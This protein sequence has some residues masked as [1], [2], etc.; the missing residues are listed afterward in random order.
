MRE[1]ARSPSRRLTFEDAVAIQ[2]RLIRR[3]FQN[4]IAA[5]YDVNSGRIAEIKSGVTF[6]GSYEA[7]LG[8]NDPAP[9]QQKL[10]G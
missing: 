6:P 2:R 7:A 5:D 1:N 3:E 4:R 10:F 9:A 8:P